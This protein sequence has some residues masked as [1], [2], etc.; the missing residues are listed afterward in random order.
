MRE[1]KRVRATG[2]RVPFPGQPG[3]FLESTKRRVDGKVV[4]TPGAWVPVPWTSYWRKRFEDGFIE[5]QPVPEVVPGSPPEVTP[6]R[7]SEV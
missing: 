2:P 4:Y 1:T 3:K 6:L 7:G 5:V